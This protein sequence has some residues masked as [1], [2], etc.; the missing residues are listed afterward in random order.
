MTARLAETFIRLK[1]EGHPLWFHD[2]DVLNACFQGKAEHH[3]VGLEH[4]VDAWV[5]FV[6]VFGFSGTS[7]KNKIIFTT[8]LGKNKP[9]SSPDMWLKFPRPAAIAYMRA[10]AGGSARGTQKMGGF[11]LLAI[12]RVFTMRR[13]G[14]TLGC[15]RARFLGWLSKVILTRRTSP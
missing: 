9:W 6:G 13:L 15:R 11:L 12:Y 10:L 14:L 3:S 7:G 8:F 5:F 1:Q 4:P 2:Q